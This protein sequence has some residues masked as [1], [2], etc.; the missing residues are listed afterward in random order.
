MNRKKYNKQEKVS[1][2]KG[3]DTK[4]FIKSL[5]IAVA[6]A[7]AIRATVIYPFTVP[8]SSMENTILVGD[9]IFA[10]KFVYG[11]RTPDW[12]GIPYTRIGFKIP[13]FRTPGFRKPQPGDVVIFKYPRD[14]YEHYVKRC[15]AVSGDTVEIRNKVVYVNGKIFPNPPHSRF[16]HRRYP[17]DFQQ[18]D[19]YPPGAGNID[20][21]GPIRI[22]APGDTFSFTDS[23]RFKWFERFQII[24]YEGHKITVDQNGTTTPLTVNNINRWHTIIHTYPAENFK[25]DGKKLTETIYT[26][27][28][29][30]YFMLGDNRDISFDS[31]Y[32]GFVPERYIV[33]EAL[34]IWMSWDKR[35]PFYQLDKKIRWNRLLR[36]IR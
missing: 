25:I 8:T 4:E 3:E 7:L 22:P 12:I 30:Q 18:G 19:I 27:K 1:R 13:F 26:V 6:I 36:L 28:Y 16:T 2:K 5:L 21:Y 14:D 20:N 31:R 35:R 32:W 11:I 15:V 34:I 29:R 24:I 17:P 10:N 9:F 23:N 33:G